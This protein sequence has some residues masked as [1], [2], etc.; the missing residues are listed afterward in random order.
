[1]SASDFITIFKEGGLVGVFAIVICVILFFIIKHFL[2]Q[3]TA[4]FNA[5][6]SAQG[7][8]LEIN[9]GWQ[10]ALDAHNAAAIDFHTRAADADK[11]QREEHKKLEDEIIDIKAITKDAHSARALEHQKMFDKLDMV[12]KVIDKCEK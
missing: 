2:D 5:F 8:F 3:N 11:Y 4:I 1:M 12:G 9:A 10:R 6:V 7:K